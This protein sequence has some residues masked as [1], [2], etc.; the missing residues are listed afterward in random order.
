VNW[1]E[2]FGGIG[3]VLGVVVGALTVFEKLTGIGQRWLARGI[4]AGVRSMREDLNDVR[5]EQLEVTKSLEE[6]KDYTRYHLGP[7]GKS[8][9]VHERITDVERAV[10]RED[11]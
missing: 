7:N 2:V 3:V 5:A 9:P 1:I 10:T 8:K 11:R 4:E 6:H